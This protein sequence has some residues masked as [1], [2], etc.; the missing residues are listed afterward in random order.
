[1][2]RRTLE[3]ETVVKN[4]ERMV[5]EAIT[6]KVDEV[7]PDWPICVSNMPQDVPPPRFMLTCVGITQENKL[8]GA[9]FFAL[10]DWHL[11]FDPGEG[12][13]EGLAGAVA[14]ALTTELRKIPYDGE[15]G[16]RGDNMESGWDE[17]RGVLDI[18]FRTRVS[19]LKAEPVA[20]PILGACIR[21]FDKRP[22]GTGPLIKRTVVRR[23]KRRHKQKWNPNTH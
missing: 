20:P 5:S 21:T 19:L 4:L 22:D 2:R 14:F 18:F 12:D 7:C 17:A 8:D 11:L 10:L 16:F 6:R 15:F 9:G 23:K 3:G 1:M 13:P